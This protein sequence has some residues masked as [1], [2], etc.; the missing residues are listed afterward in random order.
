MSKVSG[1]ADHLV[2]VYTNEAKDTILTK[3]L[4]PMSLNTFYMKSAEDMKYLRLPVGEDLFTSCMHAN[5]EG[6]FWRYCDRLSLLTVA[7]KTTLTSSEQKKFV[8]HLRHL[9]QEA[10]LPFF[11]TVNDLCVA[12]EIDSKAAKKSGSIK[13]A[14]F[15]AIKKEKRL[16][17][18]LKNTFSS[19]KVT[20]STYDGDVCILNDWSEFLA[21]L[22]GFRN[23]YATLELL[24][25]RVPAVRGGRIGKEEGGSRKGN[26]RA[27]GCDQ[28]GGSHPK[29]GENCKFNFSFVPPTLANRPILFTDVCKM[30][31]KEGLI[32][33]KA[34]LFVLMVRKGEDG[35]MIVTAY[36]PKSASDWQCEGAP[37]EW[38]EEGAADRISTDDAQATLEE[39]TASGKITIGVG[40]TPRVLCKV[41]NKMPGKGDEFLGTCE[42]SIS[43]VLSNCGQMQQEWGVLVKGGK[44][45]GRV[46]LSMQFK[47]QVDIDMEAASKAARR[48]RNARLGQE[49]K[50]KATLKVELGKMAASGGGSPGSAG[51]SLRGEL[52]VVKKSLGKVMGEK[53]SLVEE[54]EERKEE[55]LRLE[56]GVEE[57]ESKRKRLEGELKSVAERLSQ[58]EAKAAERATEGG[59]GLQRGK[60][61]A[62]VEKK[63]KGEVEVLRGEVQALRGE[64]EGAKKLAATVVVQPEGEV[65]V[66]GEEEVGVNTPPP[67]PAAAEE[68]ASFR[69]VGEARSAIVACLTKR[70]PK[71]PRKMASR[72]L[73]GLVDGGGNVDLDDVFECFVNLGLLD[74]AGFQGI[75]SYEE[76]FDFVLTGVDRVGEGHRLHDTVANFGSIMEILGEEKKKKEVEAK[77]EAEE[78]G[79]GEEE[80]VE[81]VH[82]EGWE[83]KI[84]PKDGKIYYVNH[85][86][87]TTSWARPVKK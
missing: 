7:K 74:L 12:F 13:K 1:S 27:G 73:G 46:L 11:V 54:V 36:D 85:N 45:S 20:F 5:E 35:S 53:D 50:L 82:P 61:E 48:E 8:H 68:V 40:I 51:G 78:G 55:V 69:S 84:R 30:M 25:K 18:F 14:I 75:E 41:Y 26:F 10:N 4:D 44:A 16:H 37:D 64:L 33:P 2:S 17:N 83:M 65:V 52:E 86:D 34:K 58:A 31:V 76:K 42:V 59:T 87:R 72:L 22:N 32:E 56:R 39:Y 24:P 6:A 38:C 79:E 67:P 9:F 3:V 47:R 57:A 28:E 23:P 71:E 19:L 81:D 63:W 66:G 29:F 80:G 62:E 60:I 43:G 77:A 15:S 49:R 21:H 70:N